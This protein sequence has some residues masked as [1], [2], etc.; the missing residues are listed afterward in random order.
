MRQNIMTQNIT[1]RYNRYNSTTQRHHASS[2]ELWHHV[3]CEG[4]LELNSV[5]VHNHYAESPPHY[6]QISEHI[7][8]LRKQLR[9]QLRRQLCNRYVNSCL[10]SYVTHNQ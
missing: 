2:Y 3:F 8:Q 10:Y 6:F 9:R 7:F 4:V 1:K 5:G